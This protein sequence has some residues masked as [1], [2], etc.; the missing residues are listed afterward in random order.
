M[1]GTLTERSPGK[2]QL[3]VFVGTD[4]ATGRPRQV[5]KSFHGGKRAAQ[6]ALAAFVV[7]V[8]A[9]KR[10]LT[11]ATTVAELLD[12]YI[13]YQTQL[14]QPTTIRGYRM[15]AK[16]ITVKLGKIRVS[17]LDA[18]DIDLAYREWLAEGLAPST[19]HHHHELLSAALHQAVRWR[20][21]NYAV[22]EH[23]SPPP[24]KS[25][26][27]PEVTPE[28]VRQLVTEAEHGE[29]PALGTAIALAAITGCRRGE[30]LALRWEDLDIAQGVIWVRRAV[31]HGLDSKDIVVGPTKTHAER[32]I[33][34]DRASL[35]VLAR[36]RIV[37]DGWCQGVG[38]EPA[39]T[40]YIISTDP[41]GVEPMRPDSL[42]QAYRR[43]ARRAGINLRFHD[44]RHFTATQLI[45]AGID[46]VTVAGRLGH[47]D[48]AMTLRVY[49]AI[50][51]ENQQA[52]A[53]IVGELVAP[54]DD[55]LSD[56]E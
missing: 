56:D 5:T 51:S 28:Q 4:P 41:L 21:V 25:P 30:L 33:I 12:K 43:C 18:Q 15:I 20:V 9:G 49:A 54:L 10:P 1:R 8:E 19:V 53:G 17:R 52:A 40:G 50:L 13:E 45:G 38:V 22:T 37:V 2:W 14:K 24:L 26:P 48:P 6:T 32:P 16:R 11:G 42:S 34:L 46:P 31:K 35:A 44:L 39:Q 23:A 55:A 36:W 7:E 3:R 29:S 27:V 47:A